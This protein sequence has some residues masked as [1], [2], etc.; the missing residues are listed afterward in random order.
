MHPHFILH[1]LVFLAKY[2]TAKTSVS[3]IS[4]LKENKRLNWLWED[5]GP[6]KSRRV[7]AEV[8]RVRGRSRRATES[9][10]FFE[11]HTR[12]AFVN[13]IPVSLVWMRPY[14]AVSTFIASVTVGILE[15]GKRRS[16]VLPHR[17]DASKYTMFRLTRTFFLSFKCYMFRSK[18]IIVRRK[19]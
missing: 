3:S 7:V 17:F 14:P 8:G 4:R 19:R 18:P 10:Y 6:S 16:G 13:R 1:F 12:I 9:W 2:H 5:G 15:A 11:S